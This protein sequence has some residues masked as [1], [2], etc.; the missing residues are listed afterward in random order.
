MSLR[1]VAASL[2]LMT[3]LPAAA[4]A[5]ATLTQTNDSYFRAAEAA[6]AA[7]IA[8]Q[9]S[10]GRARNVMSDVSTLGATAGSTGSAGQEASSRRR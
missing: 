3:V 5:P 4:Q 6:L 8:A 9:P 10:T 2:A 1:S 7:R